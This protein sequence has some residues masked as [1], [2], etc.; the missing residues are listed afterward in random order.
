MPE[1][2]ILIVEVGPTPSSLVRE[3]GSYGRMIERW[4]HPFV[5]D[6]RFLYNCR[7]EDEPLGPVDDLSAAIIS[8]SRFGV[9][10]EAPWMIELEEYIRTLFD[11]GIPTFG[12][13]FGHQIMAKALGGTVEKSHKGWGLGVSEYALAAD[14]AELARSVVGRAVH[15]DQIVKLPE[16]AEILGGNAHCPAAVLHYADAPFASVQFH[17]EFTRDYLSDLL[18]ILEE[19]G[20]PQAHILAAKSSLTAECTDSAV[21]R[22]A[23]SLLCN[24]NAGF[25]D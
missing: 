7:Y 12:I 16:G 21:A 11:A 23:A 5:G 1:H 24:R 22:W 15:Q 8:G 6:T 10:E 14:V 9:Y 17:P 2:R 18:P 3:Y 20:V 4:I 25:P 13:C 19:R